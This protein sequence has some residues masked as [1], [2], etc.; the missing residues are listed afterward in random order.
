MGLREIA[1]RNPQV[2]KLVGIAAV[3]IGC[4]YCVYQWRSS[5]TARSVNFEHVFF[6]V[7]DG[8]TVFV[9]D[10]AKISG[11]L[12][13]GKPAYRAYKYRCD[14]GTEFVG[15]LER[16]KPE[17]RTKLEALQA[18]GRPDPMAVREIVISGQEIKRPGDP[19]WVFRND[20]RAGAILSGLRC[21][22]GKSNESLE[23]V[24]P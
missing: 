6:T 20:A 24:T 9:D 15:Y 19:E 21:P 1:N 8:K 23:P 14:E 4:G 5:S 18:K 2:A 11:F 10:G 17:W 7:D 13:D 22:H 3:I 16:F 12:V